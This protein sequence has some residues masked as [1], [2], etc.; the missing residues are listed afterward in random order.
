MPEN[1]NLPTGNENKLPGDADPGTT[2]KKAAGADGQP[3]GTPDAGEGQEK[4]YDAAVA[5][6]NAEKEKRQAVEVEKANLE[7]Q[8]ATQNATVTQ[9]QE[10]QQQ[11]GIYKMVA[12]KLGID[13]EYATPEEQGQIF[14]SMMQIATVQQSNAGFIASK[15]DYAELVGVQVGNTFQYSPTMLRVMKAN[16]MLTTALSQS[17]NAPMLAYELASKDPQ[18]LKE[19][20]DAAKNPEVLAAEKAA[21]ALAAANKQ[22][23]IGGASGGGT[24]DK[25]AAV[26]A[27]SDEEFAAHNEKLME[28]AT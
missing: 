9:Q 21:A 12:A 25:A 11:T 16:P 14:E 19:K 13:V 7:A 17:P 8:I 4:K 26:A 24:L 23:S 3:S 22:V 27:M 2:G 20:A 1:D 10:Q 5:M 15:P 28:K 6:A 18:Y